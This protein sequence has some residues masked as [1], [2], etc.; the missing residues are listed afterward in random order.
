MSK[1]LWVDTE[2]TGL[3]RKNCST[4]SISGIVEIDGVIKEEFDIYHRPW[5][6]AEIV[7]EALERNGFTREEIEKFPPMRT[8]YNDL[9]KI[10]GRYVNKYDKNDKFIPCGYNVDFDIEFLSNMDKIAD[11]QSRFS[12]I[13]SYIWRGK[14]ICVLNAVNLLDAERGIYDMRS[15]KLEEVCK[16]EGIAIEAHK[17]MSD[18]RATKE[19]YEKLLPHFRTL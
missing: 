10:L 13:G 12:R 4:I 3:D 11:I 2:T 19:L 14:K 5:N 17:S 8:A 6:G 18:I 1:K 15:H 16:V 7:D 9:F